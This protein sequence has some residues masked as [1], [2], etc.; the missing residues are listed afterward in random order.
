MIPQLDPVESLLLLLLE[1]HFPIA[2]PKFSSKFCQI[3]HG[4]TEQCPSCREQ[5]YLWTIYLQ[6]VGFGEGCSQRICLLKTAVDKLY[7]QSSPARGL[8]MVEHLMFFNSSQPFFQLN[9]I[10]QAPTEAAVSLSCSAL[11]SS[12]GIGRN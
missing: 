9:I 8:Q 2:L 11:L 7:S 12:P 3:N 1:S 5:V 6:E 4:A 10:V